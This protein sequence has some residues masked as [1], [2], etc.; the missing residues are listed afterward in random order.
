[1]NLREQHGYTYGA[2]SAYQS[3]RAGGEFLAGGLVR[4]D[5]TAAAAKELMSEIRS[6]PSHPPTPEEL[7]AAKTASIQ[8]L[9][10][11]FE[12]TGATAGAVGTLF[13]YSRPLDYYAALPAKY[14]AVTS[15]DV[16]RV[17]REDLHPDHL[18][19]VAAGD[20]ARIEP[21]LKDAGLGP[22]E[23]RDI[24]GTVVSGPVVGPAAGG[25]K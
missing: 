1:M 24:N 7:N 11:T 14:A 20:R 22:V 10:G 5:I 25:G 17:A 23:V 4:T 16:A 12:T 18:V 3:F 9:P 6:F 13:L 15:D 21:G 19:I 8:S 2:Q